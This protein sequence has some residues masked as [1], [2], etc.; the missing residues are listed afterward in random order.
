MTELK[1]QIQKIIH[2]PVEKVLDAWLKP[3][4]LSKFMLPMSGMPEPEVENDPREGGGFTIVMQSGDDK[5]P[6]TGKYIEID[7]PN[8]LV[9]TWGQTFC[10]SVV[11][12]HSP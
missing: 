4:I 5:L 12:T 3:K 2:A 8:K 11:S 1:V 7:R 10:R 9:F 6:H